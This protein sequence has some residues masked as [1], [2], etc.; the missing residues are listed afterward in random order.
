M[1]GTP[2][3]SVIDDNMARVDLDH[4]FDLDLG[5]ARVIGTT[6][7]GE[8]VT[9]DTGLGSRADGCC[10]APLEQGFTGGVAA[11]LKDESSNSD[12]YMI[13]NLDHGVAVGRLKRGHTET[14]E[15]LA[16]LG[17]SD[18]F[19][20]VVVAGLEHNVVVLLQLGVD[21]GS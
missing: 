13:T 12:T 11:R 18:R 17:D 7:T 19:T 20:E 9:H 21:G 14:K 2:K 4:A 3:P 15:N 8:N 6:N 16:V 10:G 5:L 1:I